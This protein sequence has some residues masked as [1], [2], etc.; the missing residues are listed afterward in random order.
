MHRLSPAEG[1]DTRRPVRRF[2]ASQTQ[3][4]VRRSDCHLPDPQGNAPRLRARD[5]SQGERRPRPPRAWARTMA[6]R[7]SR[8]V[9]DTRHG[10]CRR[11]R[12]R[13]TKDP[14]R[15][16]ALSFDL[17]AEDL[18]NP[19]RNIRVTTAPRAC[20]QK[21]PLTLSVTEVGFDRLSGELR[22]GHGASLGFVSE[23]SVKVV[24]ELH[25]GPLHGNHT[26]IGEN[27]AAGHQ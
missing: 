7:G 11:R 3:R 27:L 14:R 13:R 10:V 1:L 21:A 8:G 16:G 25:G 23:T 6:L 20:C 26:R 5:E 17:V 18:F 2:A 12:R 4:L 15:Q 19:F 9:R 22:H 24:R